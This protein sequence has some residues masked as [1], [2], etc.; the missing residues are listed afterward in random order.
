MF[1]QQL[2]TEVVCYRLMKALQ[3]LII[4]GYRPK[5][6]GDFEKRSENCD[7]KLAQFKKRV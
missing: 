1:D 6:R 2:R 3:L 4:G 5:T 7:R